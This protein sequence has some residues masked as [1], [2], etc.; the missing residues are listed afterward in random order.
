MDEIERDEIGRFK[1]GHKVPEKIRKK[2]RKKISKSSKG[3]RLSKEVLERRSE[4]MKREYKLGLRKKGMLG[5]KWTDKQRKK[6]SNSLKLMYKK[7]IKKPIKLY[8]KDNPFYGKSHSEESK[9]KLRLANLGKVQSEETLYKRSIAQKGEKGS[10]W[11]GGIS[12]EPYDKKFNN[13]FKRLIRKR[14]N[15]ICMMCGVHREKLSRALDV[16]HINYD[17]KL[18]IPENCISLCNSCHT[19]T[20]FNRKHWIRFFQEILLNK[21]DYNYSEEDSIILEVVSK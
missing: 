13:A 8:G 5:K 6:L 2:I 3:R 15:Q 11:K 16:H 12:F 1:K 4:Q 21:Y 18:T 20:G 10:N 14:D 9:N 17:K 7:G 19:K